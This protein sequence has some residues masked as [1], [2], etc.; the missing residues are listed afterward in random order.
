MT[1]LLPLPHPM[2]IT[3]SCWEISKVGKVRSDHRSPRKPAGPG[4]AW[5]GSMEPPSPEQESDMRNTESSR[6][7]QGR[8]KGIDQEVSGLKRSRIGNHQE[9][10]ANRLSYA[11]SLGETKI[12]LGAPH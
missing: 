2:A 6:V 4:L 11:L 8:M 7:E 12:N 9:N 10:G 5:V 3:L 1:V